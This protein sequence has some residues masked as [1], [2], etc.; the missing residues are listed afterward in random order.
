LSSSSFLPF[1]SLV[2]KVWIE[3]NSRPIVAVT[4]S[5][6]H[7]CLFGAI[8]KN[9]FYHY[10]KLVHCKFPKCYP[11]LNKTPQHYKSQNVKTFFEKHKD[12]LIPTGS[13]MTEFMVLRMLECIEE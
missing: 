4:G 6:R 2:R 13:M 9:S 1:D 11:F 3:K 7:K 10:L 12:V 8:S 5:H